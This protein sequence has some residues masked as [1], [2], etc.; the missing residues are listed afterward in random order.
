MPGTALR[1]V[2]SGTI[3]AVIINLNCSHRKQDKGSTTQDKSLLIFAHRKNHSTLFSSVSLAPC[4]EIGHR[5]SRLVDV[6]DLG[7]NLGWE[8]REKENETGLKSKKE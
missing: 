7:M 1:T 3:Q 8:E 2:G 4:L 6:L 5:Q